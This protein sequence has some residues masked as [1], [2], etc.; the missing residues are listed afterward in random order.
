MGSGRSVKGEGVEGL[1][2][3]RGA[4]PRRRNV[5]RPPVC[6]AAGGGWGWGRGTG[7]SSPQ[8]TVTKMVLSSGG[9]LGL[10]SPTLRAEARLG[11]WTALADGMVPT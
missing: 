1:G 3:D 6:V 5:T 7:V 11:A 4:G 2:E 8:F 10:G 9:I